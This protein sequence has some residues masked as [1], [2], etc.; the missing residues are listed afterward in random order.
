MVYQTYFGSSKFES[1][2]CLY[3]DSLQ[4]TGRKKAPFPMPGYIG[5][6]V[7]GITAIPSTGRA[8]NVEVSFGPDNSKSRMSLDSPYATWGIVGISKK[9]PVA[10]NCLTSLVSLAEVPGNPTIDSD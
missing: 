1:Y 3:L 10:T 8:T 4:I 9:V 2:R 5:A 7:N 6:L